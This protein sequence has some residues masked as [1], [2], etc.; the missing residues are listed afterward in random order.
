MMIIRCR[1]RPP[2]HLQRYSL[3]LEWTL[4]LY[5]HYISS[6]W[7]LDYIS[8][9]DNLQVLIS[10]IEWL[11]QYLNAIPILPTCW[12]LSLVLLL[13]N[14]SQNFQLS[15]SALVDLGAVHKWRHHL[16]GRG[17]GVWIPPKIDD[18]IYEQPLLHMLRSTLS[19][20]KLFNIHF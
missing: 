16:R 2:F 1:R 7:Y 6:K 14:F 8:I 15:K 3:Y 11:T 17:G 10:D 12:L 18:A 20:S 4:S 5:C 9:S 13:H 19:L